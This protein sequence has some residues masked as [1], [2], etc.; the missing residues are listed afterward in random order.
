MLTAEENELFTRVGPGTPC[1]D[2]F[3]CYWQPVA[4]L[5]ELSQANPTKHVRILG[6]DL[7]L[8]QDKN[9][10]VGL[11][12]DHCP[13]RGASLLYGRVEERGIACA[14]HGWL[15]DTQGNCLETP[16]EP[17]DSLLHL[18][19]KHTAYPIREHYGLYWAYMGPPPAPLLP[20]YDVAELGPLTVKLTAPF[21]CNW[22]QVVENNLDQSHVFILHQSTGGGGAK[23]TNTTRGRIDELERL[24]YGEAP[25]GIRRSQVHKNGYVETD[26]M[27]FPASQRNSNFFHVKV[28]ID[29]T[30][31]WRYV[32]YTDLP[33]QE[34]P[35]VAGGRDGS[36]EA[37]A[38]YTES[39]LEGK[40]PSD[41]VHPTARYRIDTL[42]FEDFTIL[43]TQGPISDREHERLGIADSG[44]VLLREILRREIEKVQQGLDPI[45]VVRDPDQAPLNTYIDT[46]IDIL[47][48]GLRRVPSDKGGVRIYPGGQLASVP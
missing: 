11:L 45:G 22:F 2:L 1:G 46:Y 10:R 18:T 7:V 15:Y 33:L 8:F 9:G 23:P 4:M 31:T 12:A 28:P 35:A 41:A 48:R 5:P 20:R 43:E 21:A 37:V 40:S 47:R 24:E 16:A 27:I 25:G 36:R 38:Y 30:H 32:I 19:V 26:L 44:V 14:Y 13:H 39:L 17:A 29:D 42:R 3:R 6:E 34:S